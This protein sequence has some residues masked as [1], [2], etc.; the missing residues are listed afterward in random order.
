MTQRQPQQLLLIWLLLTVT[1]AAALFVAWQQG[2][3]A[4]LYASDRSYIA[5]LVSA[6]FVLS[7]CHGGLRAVQLSRELT[8]ADSARWR[9]RQ[10]AQPEPVTAADAATVRAAL[11]PSSVQA[12]LGDWLANRPAARDEDTATA[13]ELLR[14]YEYQLKH[15]QELGWLAT[16]VMLKL[17]LVGTI[18]GF[19]MMLA[20]VAGIEDF[21]VSSMQGVLQLM[22]GG[23]A[24][25]LYT[26]LTGI[27]CS[28]LA[29]F[30]YYILDKGA[31]HIVDTM[32]YISHALIDK[33]AR[34]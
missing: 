6:L 33:T 7:W 2:Y 3:L 9:Y 18:V 24:T 25:A 11:P 28:M 10:A 5:W 27:T 21:D 8:R 30:Q 13:N 31:N 14:S 17:G 12:Y 20:S 1:I 26:T 29:G 19:I 23:M 32:R 22:S 15:P 34:S 16:D 4:T